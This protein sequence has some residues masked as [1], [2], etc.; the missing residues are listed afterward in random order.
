MMPGRPLFY[1]FGGLRLDVARRRLLRNGEA[2]SVAPKPFETLLLLV[3]NRGLVLEKDELM[4]CLWPESFVE[5]ANLSQNIFVLRKLLGDGR[6]GKVFIQTIPRRGYKFVAA[7]QE[8]AGQ[9]SAAMAM[10]Q[11][12]GAYTALGNMWW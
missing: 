10:L 9:E 2:L 8:V 7:V 11:F 1:E 5:E 12:S 6:G 4:K 3:E